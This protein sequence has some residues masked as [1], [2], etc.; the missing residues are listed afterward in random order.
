MV[1]QQLI[2]S[3]V[4]VRGAELKSWYSTIFSRIQGLL[5]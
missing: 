4:F 3:L 2:V 5:L 1:I